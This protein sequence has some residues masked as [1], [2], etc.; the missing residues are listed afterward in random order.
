MVGVI[1]KLVRHLSRL[2]CRRFGRDNLGYFAYS[3][4]YEATTVVSNLVKLKPIFIIDRTR[5]LGISDTNL[6]CSI[7]LIHD[8]VTNYFTPPPI[9]LPRNDP[10][11]TAQLNNL[12]FYWVRVCP[13]PGIDSY[14][15]PVYS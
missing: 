7:G 10:L 5:P 1:V 13:F 6:Q 4:A 15:R 2:Q 3:S 14:D 8:I 9:S 12:V 11:N